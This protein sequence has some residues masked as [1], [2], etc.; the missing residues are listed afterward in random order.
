[1]RTWQVILLL[2]AVAAMS[3]C[4]S[5]PLPAGE[6]KASSFLGS[7]VHKLKPGG[8]GQPA[9]IYMNPKADWASYDKMLLD[10]VTFWRDPKSDQEALSQHDKQM[11]VN[12]FYA[13]IAKA[14]SKRVTMVNAPGP[15]VMRVK[16]AVTKADPSIV[17]LD[18]VSTVLPQAIAFSAIKTA[19]TGKPAFV[20]EARVAVKVT[21]AASGELL[22]AWVAARVGAKNLDKAEFSSWGDVEQAMSFWANNA[23]YHLCKLQKRTDCGQP[24]KP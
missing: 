9:W 10:P 20:G 22:A 8:P 12:Y 18:V 14:M 24:P 16:V 19:L 13:V 23:A 11:L 7:D 21:D 5:A 1:M 3:A 15:G 17:A 4:A 6:V 2:A